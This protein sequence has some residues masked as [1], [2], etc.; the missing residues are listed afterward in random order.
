MQKIVY[1]NYADAYELFAEGDVLLFRGQKFYSK[2]IQAGTASPYTHVGVA[3]KPNGLWEVVFFHGKTGGATQ[4]IAQVC[5]DEGPVIDIYRPTSHQDRSY[6]IPQTGEVYSFSTPFNGKAVTNIMRKMTGLPYGWRRIWWI[7]KYKL[8]LHNFLFSHNDF[9]LDDEVK[10]IVYPICSS[11]VAY[12]FNR[13]G[14]DLI[15]NKGDN[16]TT[17][18]DLALS[19]NLNYLFT[20]KFNPETDQKFLK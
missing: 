7:F 17:P 19:P 4:N 3:S 15:K 1:I 20:I 9:I 12:A 5:K 10:D 18:A 8:F 13:Y 2:F 16:W 11:T 6:F 14:I